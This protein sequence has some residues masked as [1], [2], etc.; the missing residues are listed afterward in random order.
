MDCLATFCYFLELPTLKQKLASHWNFS[1]QPSAWNEFF[2]L[3]CWLWI[4]FVHR[5][6]WVCLPLSREVLRT[7][8][9]LPSPLRVTKV[10]GDHTQC[11][12]QFW[13][14]YPRRKS[15]KLKANGEREMVKTERWK[16]KDYCLRFFLAWSLEK[17]RVLDFLICLEGFCSINGL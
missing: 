2:S 14:L 4:G 5:M 3:V 12:A 15:R 1:Y 16:W 13:S 8:F 6:Y 17:D 10:Q 11:R 7:A 9:L